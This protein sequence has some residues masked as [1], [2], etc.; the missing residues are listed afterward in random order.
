[1]RLLCC[2]VAGLIQTALSQVILLWGLGSS[3]SQPLL[4]NDPSQM[5][6]SGRNMIS[7]PWAVS[8]G[9]AGG[10]FAV[11]LIAASA[12]FGTTPSCSAFCQKMSK[13]GT[14]AWL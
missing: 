12:V 3:C 4:A 9:E 11:T 8:T 2:A 13:L 7:R 10:V 1:L 14:L 5:V 6:G